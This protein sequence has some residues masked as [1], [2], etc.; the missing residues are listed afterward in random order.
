MEWTPRPPERPTPPLPSSLEE[1][2]DARYI[3]NCQQCGLSVSDLM[4]LS[5]RQVR[6]L[7]EINGFY[8]DAAAHYEDDEQARKS[9]AAF[10]S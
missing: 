1:A 3:Y 5:Y 7:L 8:A 6:D 10:W 9:E 4:A 2:C